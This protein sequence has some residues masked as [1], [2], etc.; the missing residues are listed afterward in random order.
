MPT[1]AKKLPIVIIAAQVGNLI[2]S[3][4]ALIHALAESGALKPARA[5]AL[6]RNM[7]A[8]TDNP[9]I[10]KSARGVTKLIGQRAPA[11]STGASKRQS[12]R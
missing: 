5:K 8:V 1:E 2:G 6:I 12:D 9:E 11:K 10:M 7:A 3:H 4:F